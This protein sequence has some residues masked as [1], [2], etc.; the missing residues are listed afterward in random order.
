MLWHARKHQHSIDYRSLS[1]IEQLG[2]QLAAEAG[3]L[4]ID[5]LQ[6]SL[7]SSKISSVLYELRRWLETMYSGHLSFD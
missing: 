2:T 3:I 6:L 7:R 4:Q 1:A 5:K